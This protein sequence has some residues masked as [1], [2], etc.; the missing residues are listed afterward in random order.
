MVMWLHFL[1]NWNGISLFLDVDKSSA[2]DMNLY[3]DASGTI[4]Y[5][6]FFQGAWFCGSWSQSFLC[7]LSEKISIAFQELYPIVVAAILWG[8]QWER[9]RIIFHCDNQATVHIL[10]KGNSK[11]RDIMKLMRRLTLVAANYSFTF[12]AKHVIGQLN[13]VADSLS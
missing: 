4:G 6:G 7:N 2:D 10:N 3:T 8:K 11:S 1:Q 9:K 5:G 12:T 13:R